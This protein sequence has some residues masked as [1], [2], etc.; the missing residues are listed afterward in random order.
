MRGMKLLDACTTTKQI[1][2]TGRIETNDVDEFAGMVAAL[3]AFQ[4]AEVFHFQT[5]SL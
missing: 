3:L 4:I 2:F 5:V 1:V